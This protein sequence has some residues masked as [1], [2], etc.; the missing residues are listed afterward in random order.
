MILKAWLKNLVLDCA[1]RTAS[2]DSKNRPGIDFKAMDGC[3]DRDVS[4]I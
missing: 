4:E 2:L 1:T 3:G